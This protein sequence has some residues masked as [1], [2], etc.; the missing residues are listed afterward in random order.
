M[1]G[2][3][4]GLWR[5]KASA[6]LEPFGITFQQYQLVRQ[7]RRKGALILS[8]AAGELGMD[9]PTLSLV[10]RKCVEA[11]W[12]TRTDSMTDRRASRLSLSG[13][14]EELLDKIEALRLFSPESLGD[15]LDVLGSEERSELKR[16]M[17]RVSRRARDVFV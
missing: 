11:G 6:A 10:A 5:R 14:G 17:D 8:A 12:L 3:A 4:Y 1:M 9:K 15:A 7:A 13:L 2:L 16:M